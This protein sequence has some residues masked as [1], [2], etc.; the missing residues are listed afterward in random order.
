MLALRGTMGKNYN[1]LFQMSLEGTSTSLV[2]PCHG[3]LWFTEASIHIWSAISNV[4]GP[5]LP[6]GYGTKENKPFSNSIL[7]PDL[8]MNSADWFTKE[9]KPITLGILSNLQFPRK[10]VI[11]K[12]SLVSYRPLIFKRTLVSHITGNGTSCCKRPW[13]L[14]CVSLRRI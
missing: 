14:I 2:T 8:L 1:R 12:Q 4:T 7:S 6:Q 3:P 5:L 13:L 9:L 11:P 10:T